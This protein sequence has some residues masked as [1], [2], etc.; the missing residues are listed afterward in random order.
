M[1]GQDV[2]QKFVKKQT[3]LVAGVDEVGIGALAGPVIAAAVILDPNSPVEGVTDSKKISE[4][5][6]KILSEEIKKFAFD[7]AIGQASIEEI[8]R[9]NILNASHLAM[10]RAVSDLSCRPSLILVD[11]NKVPEFSE[12]AESIVKGDQKIMAIGAASI[13]AKVFRDDLM[14]SFATGY[15][16]YGFEKH[17][18][19][20]TKDHAKQ[21]QLAGPCKLHRKSF[22]P[23]KNWNIKSL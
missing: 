13:L 2:S 21:L 16:A 11:G 20:P 14:K 6:R 1:V 5:K 19:Y 12:K 15:P 3:H 22:A 23:V 9:I 18:G 4:K 10:Q 7:W 17:K 8:D